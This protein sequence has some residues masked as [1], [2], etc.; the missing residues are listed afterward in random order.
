MALCGRLGI[1]ACCAVSYACW[2]QL[3]AVAG[4]PRGAVHGLDGEAAGTF[5][6]KYFSAKASLRGSGHGQRSMFVMHV[7]CCQ[8]QEQINSA[9]CW[10]A[11][12]EDSCDA[13]RRAGRGAHS[14]S[15]SSSQGE[16]QGDAT[17][18]LMHEG[19]LCVRVSLLHA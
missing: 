4:T 7:V 13:T 12:D 2:P 6:W 19:S 9:V 15:M 17:A 16:W 10:F 18:V 11:E 3:E 8:Q 14:C 5:L 1:T